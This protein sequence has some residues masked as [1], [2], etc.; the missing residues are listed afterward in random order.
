[1]VWDKSLEIHTNLNDRSG[2]QT[3]LVLCLSDYEMF[4]MEV[5]D[6]VDSSKFQVQ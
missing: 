6:V 1:M 3:F 2:L 4:Q 5:H